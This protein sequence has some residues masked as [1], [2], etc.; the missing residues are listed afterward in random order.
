MFLRNV[1]RLSTDYKDLY[2][3]KQNS[4]SEET[5][6]LSSTAATVKISVV[7]NV[8]PCSPVDFTDVSKE[9]S[10]VSILRIEHMEIVGS[11]E[12]LVYIY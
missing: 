7:L 6:R 1:R 9:H 12:I 4:S 3:R 8:T 5:V 2:R 11:S 10:A